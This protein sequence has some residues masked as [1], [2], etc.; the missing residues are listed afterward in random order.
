M[1]RLHIIS[2]VRLYRDGLTHA[3]G[4]DARFAVVASFASLDEAVRAASAPPEVLLI[5]MA[6][7][8]ALQDLRHAGEAFPGAKLV[9]LGVVRQHDDVIAC[10][11]AGVAG[12]VFRD[13]SL[14]ELIETIEAAARGELRCSPELA[15]TLLR[16]VANLA[17]QQPPIVA[18]ASI[19][20]RE[21][22]ILDLVGEGFSNKQ[23][24]A[25][26][27]IEVATVKNHVHNILE[28]LGV[29]TRG[30]AAATLRRG[31]SVRGTDQQASIEA[32]R[33][34]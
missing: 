33:G 29:R 24:A 17:A 22:E 19:T 13:A 11:E 9:A 5:D 28:K 23:I 18:D 20:R 32:A 10:A 12:Y 8:E 34:I 6:H 7:A 15:A 4:R 30:E 16:R 31:R 14:D 26:L 21:R 1:L 27:L 3:L 2:H 25:H